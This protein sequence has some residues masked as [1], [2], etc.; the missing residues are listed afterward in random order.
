MRTTAVRDGDQW[1]LNGRKIWI[2]RADVADFS[3]VMAVTDKEKGAR[4]GISAFL[5]DSGTPGL[6]IARKIPML[7]GR[8]R[9]A[10]IVTWDAAVAFAASGPSSC[11]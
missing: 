6:N 10:Q 8:Q 2:T 11:R 4:G 1:V 9:P 7:G 5:V 3:I